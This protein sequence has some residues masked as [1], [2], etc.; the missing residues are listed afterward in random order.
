MKQGIPPAA[1]A[2]YV[3]RTR[4]LAQ[5]A[6]PPR[7]MRALPSLQALLLAHREDAKLVVFGTGG[8]ATLLCY[9]RA[10]RRCLRVR[11]VPRMLAKEASKQA[12][13]CYRAL[14]MVVGR[15]STTLQ[16]NLTNTPTQLN[17]TVDQT[18]QSAETRLGAPELY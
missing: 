5:T 8:V 9:T 6:G 7:G 3:L 2:R 17:D 11:G 12:Y 18:Q 14:N 13:A 15:V 4:L 10:C 16:S 1:A